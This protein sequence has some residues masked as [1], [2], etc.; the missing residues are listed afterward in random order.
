[1]PKEMCHLVTNLKFLLVLDGWDELPGS[2][3][4]SDFLRAS[5]ASVSFQT[6]ILITSRPE[7]SLHLH[8]QVNRVSIIGFTE[9][10]IDEYFRNAFH[11]ELVSPKDVHSACD[12]LSDHFRRYP[13]I[14]SCC[15]VP[16]NAAILAYVYLSGGQ[17]LPITRFELFRDPVLCCIKRELETH[18]PVRV[19]NDVTSFDDLP[20]DLSEQL[21]NLCVL[22]YEGVKNNKIVFPQKELP[23]VKLPKDFPTLGLLESVKGYGPVCS[24]Q[25]TYNFIHLA[26]QEL[27]AAY[28]IS[29]V[30]SDK[31]AK[32][33]E[34]L[35]VKS[36]SSAVLQFYSAFSQLSNEGVRNIITKCGIFTSGEDNQKCIF[37][38]NFRVSILNCF[39]EAQLRD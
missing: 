6:V 25:I 2:F 16:L 14:K 26:V 15:Y 1:M 31:H 23:S 11:S 27:L 8:G 21:H 17:S 12:K 28:Y 29:K 20:H 10:D 18:E 24:R 4:K 32:V 33:F 36:C 22:A 39:F 30:E 13:I 5:L 19:L 37:L 9:K 38:S 7:S 34:S 35:L 3:S